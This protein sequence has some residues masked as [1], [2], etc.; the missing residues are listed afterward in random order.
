MSR[1]FANILVL[2]ALLFPLTAAASMLGLGSYFRG[3]VPDAAHDIASDLDDQIM[4]RFARATSGMSKSDGQ[5][6]VRS[7]IMIMGTSPVNLGDMDESS[8]LARQL[9][10]EI[11]TKL[12]DAGYRYQELRKGTYI[13]FD[14]GSGEFLLT[15]NVKNLTRRYGDAPLIMV[16]TYTATDKQVRFTISLLQTTTNEV[17]AKASA[18]VPITSDMRNLLEDKNPKGKKAANSKLPTT[19][20]RLQ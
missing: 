11:S 17:V 7:Q 14:R 9:T 18:T 15:R 3:N 2:V 20:T 12:M 13:R 10:E 8:P 4:S 1:F 19:Y 6:M 5:K 16:G